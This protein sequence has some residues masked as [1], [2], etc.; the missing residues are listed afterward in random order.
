MSK[1]LVRG[2]EAMGVSP[3]AQVESLQQQKPIHRSPERWASEQT[4]VKGQV[5]RSE[6]E[7]V[8]TEW[9]VTQGMRRRVGGLG[10]TA[11]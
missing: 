9:S 4:P 11:S 8:R 3:E 6:A 2:G 10:D 5:H 1:E 7:L